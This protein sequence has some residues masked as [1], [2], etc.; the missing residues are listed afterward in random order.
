MFRTASTV[1]MLKPIA[2]IVGLAIILWSLGLPS[3]R[4]AE[5]VNITDVKDTLTDSAPSAAS[6]HTIQLVS[7]TGIATSSTIVIAFPTGAFGLGFIGEEDIDVLV[8]GVNR[9]NALWSTATTADSITLTF[10]GTS[11]PANAT[12]TILVGLHATNQGTPNTQITNPAAE[13][14]Y[15]INIDAGASDS[16]ATRVVILTAVTVTATVNTIFTFTVSGVNAGG[17]V[18]GEAIEGTTGSTTIPFGVLESGN[19]TSSAQLLTVGTNA[20]N[21]YVVTMQIDSPLQSSTGADIDGF[22]NG[23]NTNVPSTW[24]APTGVIGSENTYGH[25]GVTSDDTTIASRGTQFGNNLFI[26]ASTSPREIMQHGGP[27][28][29]AGVGVGTTTV[30]YKVAISALQE[31]GDDYSTTLTYIATPTF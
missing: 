10:G 25:W 6:N 2:T 4:F 5:A 20:A 1:D 8:N 19:S 14:S 13:A 31:A 26:A 17:T 23:S 27:V 3:L 12:T 21:G 11:I 7:P 9:S 28:N 22:A 24:I 15:E 30:L 29:G 16:G 18:N